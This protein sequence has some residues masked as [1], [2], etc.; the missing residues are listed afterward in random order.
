MK[1]SDEIGNA[2]GCRRVPLNRAIN[3]VEV[4]VERLKSARAIRDIAALESTTA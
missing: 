1:L 3:A 2:G 4:R